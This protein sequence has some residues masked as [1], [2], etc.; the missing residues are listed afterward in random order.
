M[1]I[2][3]TCASCP[4]SRSDSISAMSPRSAWMMQRRHVGPSRSPTSGN[5]CCVASAGDD[6]SW[7]RREIAWLTAWLTAL[8][9]GTAACTHGSWPHASWPHAR[10][11]VAPRSW[12]VTHPASRGRTQKPS[13]LAT[14]SHLQMQKTAGSR[15]CFRPKEASGWRR[16]SSESP[17]GAHIR[18]IQPLTAGWPRLP[19]L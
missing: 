2:K 4:S 3:L 5:S 13:T 9:Q 8:E 6:A 7:G 10:S 17:G 16:C 1:A 19:C 15:P 14:P 12:L 11:L 18:D